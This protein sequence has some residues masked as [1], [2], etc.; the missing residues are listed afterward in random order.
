MSESIEEQFE[1]SWYILMFD[2]TDRRVI[3]QTLYKDGAEVRAINNI[4]ALDYLVDKVYNRMAMSEAVGQTDLVSVI[5]D[6]ATTQSDDWVNT[7][8][9]N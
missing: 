1:G 3:V 9:G 7:L 2:W 8:K 5:R 6:I 4:D